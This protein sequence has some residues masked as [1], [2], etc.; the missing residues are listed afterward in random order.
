MSHHG[1]QV[2]HWKLFS[3][4]NVL[5]AEGAYLHLPFTLDPSLAV[6]LPLVSASGSV[7]NIRWM[8]VLYQHN[9]SLQEWELT[10]YMEV[11]RQVSLPRMCAYL[12]TPL[13]TKID[14]KHEYHRVLEFD[15]TVL[16]P[17]VYGRLHPYH[18]PQHQ[19]GISRPVPRKLDY[20]AT[21][22]EA[23]VNAQA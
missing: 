16:T 6:H 12:R 4:V 17:Y 2:Y 11:D 19:G 23:S 21:R 22:S 14:M 18:V 8:K 15:L 20:E 9:P 13:V 7:V 3:K 5:S 10:G 1:R